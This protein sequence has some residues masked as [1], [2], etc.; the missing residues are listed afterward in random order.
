MEEIAKTMSA[1]GMPSGFHDGSA[2]LYELM[3][4]SPYASEIRETVDKSRTMRQT[5]EGC[6]AVVGNK[7]AAE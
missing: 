1:I 4:K 5:V 7:D 6:A 3:T 2:E